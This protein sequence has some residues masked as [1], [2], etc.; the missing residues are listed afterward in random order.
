MVFWSYP[1]TRKQLAGSAIVFATG[2]TLFAAASPRRLILTSRFPHQFI[3]LDSNC[4][5]YSNLLVTMLHCLRSS[6]ATTSENINSHQLPLQ[7]ITP[8][9]GSQSSPSLTNEYT[10][11]LQT[12]S[13]SEI[14][15][16]LDIETDN[17][18]QD[19]LLSQYLRPNGEFVEEIL[20]REEPS[21]TTGLL[22]SFFDHSENKARMCL[23][24]SQAI[25]R[26]RTLIAPLQDLLLVLPL[27]SDSDSLSS[28]QRTRAFDLLLNY[29]QLENPFPDP[30]SR[31][32]RGMRHCFQDLNEQLQSQ[33][34][35]SNL[36]IRFLHRATISSAVFLILVTIGVVVA[37]VVVAT[38][39]LVALGVTTLI[40]V[41]IPS[42]M[43]KKEQLRLAWL[44]AAQR[45]TFVLHEDIITIER[46][47]NHL[48]SDI[49]V[50]K[51]FIRS[52]LWRGK[53]LHSIME[54]SRQIKRSNVSFQK[55]LTDLDEHLCL[56]FAA[57]NRARSHLIQA[58][59]VN[60]D[61]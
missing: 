20:Q 9:S 19:Q 41:C 5:N 7:D 15:V 46:L 60:R 58:I 21:F 50:N 57:I 13:Y 61:H 40:P 3:K 43:E 37:G 24:L 12:S 4:I 51:R 55:Q 16:F 59:N 17:S 22:W 53:D 2:A 33:I 42:K 1:P 56:S 47:V 39:A 38:H 36:R 23:D 48:Y 35:K 52:G 45:G 49:E 6:R 11:A 54:V 44:D 29:E 31:N 26:A 28:P 10:S 32:V 8:R 27:D 14:R 30:G 18:T 34:N 25:R